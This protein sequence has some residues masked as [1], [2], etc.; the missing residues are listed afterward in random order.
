M[1]EKFSQFFTEIFQDS[2]A[3]RKRVNKTYGYNF[4]FDS[5]Q[6][7]SHTESVT[8]PNRMKTCHCIIHV[9]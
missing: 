4:A 1:T 6:F 2:K 9:S 5:V 3:I 7:H 8:R